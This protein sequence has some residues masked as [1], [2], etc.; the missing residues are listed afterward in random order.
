[1]SVIKIYVNN[2]I[3]ELK[4]KDEITS[5]DISTVD[6]EFA[7]SSEW[8][9]YKK[10]ILFYTGL[11]DKDE[12]TW[13]VLKGD[14]IEG[15]QIPR[16][17]LDKPTFLSI[18]IFGDNDNNQRISTNIITK[19]IDLGTPASDT[20]SEVDYSLYN[21]IIKELIE[22]ERTTEVFDN[23]LN[24]GIKEINELVTT[25]TKEY[26]T[27]ATDKVN[28]IKSLADLRVNEIK[29]LATAKVNE[30]DDIARIK[31]EEV[32]TQA[33]GHIGNINS[34]T[35]ANINN[36]NTITGTN[37]GNINTATNNGV[38]TINTNVNRGISNVKDAV[39]SYETSINNLVRNSIT[40]VND[41]TNADISVLNK[42]TNEGLAKMNEAEDV[43]LFYLG[44]TKT[45]HVWERE[46]NTY[47]KEVDLSNI[48]VL[49]IKTNN[50]LKYVSLMVVFDS[51][52]SITI[53]DNMW[54]KRSKD[55]G[56]SKKVTITISL[57]T[58]KSTSYLET[59]KEATSILTYTK[60]Q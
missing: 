7:F 23:K 41:V 26:E 34:V 27:L 59:K 21:Q 2:E 14:R 32:A 45:I 58:G 20:D 17:L 40:N 3:A 44:V 6:I 30:L 56:N 18:G 5:G 13:I 51:G 25:K 37:I 11:Y 36:I 28:E 29:D 47:K 60:E 1:M 4:E 24:S 50:E 42:V 10:T 19:R 12:A 35:T 55:W 16:K 49:I 48:D 57:D 46:G 31:V 9:G 43:Y 22:L 33:N 53:S 15:S 38:N 39:S 8:D 54:K 52:E